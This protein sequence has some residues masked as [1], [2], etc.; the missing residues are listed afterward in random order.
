MSLILKSRKETVEY[1]ADIVCN[2][3]GKS[4]DKSGLFEKV[5]IFASWGYYSKKDTERW[6]AHLCEECADLFKAWIESAGGK[7][8]ISTEMID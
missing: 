5:D 4:C 8:D 2:R 1:I 3:C 6:E 7:I